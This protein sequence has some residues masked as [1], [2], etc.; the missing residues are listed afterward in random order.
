MAAAVFP[1]K[2]KRWFRFS[3]FEKIIFELNEKVSLFVKRFVQ[4]VVSFSFS[5]ELNGKVSLIEGLWPFS[6]ASGFG[7]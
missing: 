3:L 5:F 2:G 6:Y 7:I 1:K 4:T